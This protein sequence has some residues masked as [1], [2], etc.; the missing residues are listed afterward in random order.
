L[1]HLLQFLR[2]RQA[3]VLV[4][5]DDSGTVI[6]KLSDFGMARILKLNVNDM[7]VTQNWNNGG[8]WSPPEYVDYND[9]T[10]YVGPEHPTKEGD[11]W[12]YSMTVLVSAIIVF[13]DY[14]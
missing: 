5:V 4:E 1:P 11:I 6:P 3:N 9:K 7:T 14:S 8:H 2:L 12:M 13:H 10:L